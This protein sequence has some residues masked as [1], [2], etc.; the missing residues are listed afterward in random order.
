MSVVDFDSEGITDLRDA[1][2]A[3]DFRLRT[4]VEEADR[5]IKGAEKKWAGDTHAA[6]LR[7]YQ[8]W[9]K[10]V[11]THFDALRKTAEQLTE[12]VDQHQQIQ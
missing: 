2:V 5:K 1:L 11:M 3:T 7:F 10:G 12:L 8:D 6:F 4:A 9:R